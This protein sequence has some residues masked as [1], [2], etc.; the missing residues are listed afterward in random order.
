MNGLDSTGSREA[1]NTRT[2][3]SLRPK[4]N[5]SLDFNI[6]EL[7]IQVR[8]VVCKTIKLAGLFKHVREK[9]YSK[10]NTSGLGL[11]LGQPAPKLKRTCTVASLFP[12]R[13]IRTEALL[14]RYT[15]RTRGWAAMPRMHIAVFSPLPL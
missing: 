11:E 5:L 4:A 7:Y 6:K 8:Q 9:S 3:T 12:P 14:I 10:I 13:H 1:D 15:L 2:E